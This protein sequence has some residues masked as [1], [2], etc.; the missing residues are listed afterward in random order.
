MASIRPS[1]SLDMDYDS[2]HNQ[3]GEFT[4][5]LYRA[6][7][8]IAPITVRYHEGNL[9][10]APENIIRV[11]IR[12]S[13][14]YW[15]MDDPDA[16]ALWDGMMPR[17]LRNITEKLSVTMRQ[18]RAVREEEG[19]ASVPV[20]ACEFEFLGHAIIRIPTREDSTLPP[21]AAQMI[22]ACREQMNGCPGDADLLGRC[23]VIS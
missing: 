9:D 19:L 20:C 1:I 7:L 12:L 15:E 17:W 22:C 16:C 3:D 23:V 11:R 18:F 21:D 5:A 2:R 4:S 6:Y 10:E 13:R 14:P 8:Y